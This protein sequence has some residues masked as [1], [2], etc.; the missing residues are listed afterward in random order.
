MTLHTPRIDSESV[1]D[2]LRYRALE[3]LEEGLEAL[4]RAPT[5]RGRVEL[6]VARAAGGRRENPDRVRLEADAG[7]PGDAWGRQQG[8]HA[9]R[10]ITVMQFDV[11]ELIANGQPLALFG[12]NLF[13]SLDLSTDNLP[14]GS[15]VRAGGA[16]LEVTP[17]PHN[18][19]R[20]F[21][22]RFGA[23]AQ[24]FVSEPELRHRNLRGIYMRTVEG[25]EVARGDA[26]EVILRVSPR[27]ADANALSRL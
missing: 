14:P 9:E 1:G 25:G 16:V 2:P 18:G 8:P 4:P 24:Q 23:D 5:E 13:L 26:V 22:A 20:K 6:I 27:A 15:R 17:M 12:D 11:A 7:V 10:A 3:E 21:R 19:C